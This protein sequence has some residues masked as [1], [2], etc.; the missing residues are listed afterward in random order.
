MGPIGFK[1]ENF[2]PLFQYVGKDK[3]TSQNQ[4]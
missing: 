1:K 4:Q 3:I 2:K